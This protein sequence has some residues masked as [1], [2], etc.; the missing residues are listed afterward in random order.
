MVSRFHSFDP[1]VKEAY[2][3]FS[4]DLKGH[5]EFREYN[6]PVKVPNY[7]PFKKEEIVRYS[8]I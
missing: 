4:R 6:A 8:E 1:Q 5:K 3:R 7:D 2:F